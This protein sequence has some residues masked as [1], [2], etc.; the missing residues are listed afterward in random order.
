MKV[1]FYIVDT[2]EDVEKSKLRHKV[3][4]DW[5]YITNKQTLE[6]TKRW[7]FD[8]K[9]INNDDPIC[10][11]INKY[12][13]KYVRN[14]EIDNMIA[15]PQRSLDDGVYHKETLKKAVR[16]IRFLE[17]DYDIGVFFDQD[18]LIM[19][20]SRNFLEEINNKCLYLKTDY[21]WHD[22]GPSD[23]CGKDKIPAQWNWFSMMLANDINRSQ[24][25]QFLIPSTGFMIG[26]KQNIG[27]ILNFVEL[28]GFQFWREE[29]FKNMQEYIIE[30][31]K[32]KPIRASLPSYYF[33]LINDEEILLHVLNKYVLDSNIVS[34][35]PSLCSDFDISLDSLQIALP[36]THGRMT[37]YLDF[38]KSTKPI[39]WH[40][41][42]EERK[43]W[44]KYLYEK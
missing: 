34:S 19:D 22:D 7:G 17:S 27:Q 35:H 43:G 25:S 14:D 36:N 31:H 10:K 38:I 29:G 42:G 32:N 9:I 21:V 4:E 15:F 6:Y 12:Y 40:L 44:I 5:E 13:D 39:F 16:W 33:H 3:P 24:K 28:S 18:I 2:Y 41:I 37:G 20:Q 26:N 8:I 1:C 11:T 23:Y 30:I